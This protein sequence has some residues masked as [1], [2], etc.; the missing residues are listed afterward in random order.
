M[1]RDIYQECALTLDRV[2]REGW[3]E[4][5]NNAA[6]KYQIKV[7]ALLAVCSRETVGENKPGDGGHGRGLMQIDDRYHRKFL[8]EHEDGYDPESNIDYA[9]G[10]LKAELNRFNGKYLR[11]F[12]AYNAGGGTVIKAIHAGQDPDTYTANRDYGKDTLAR[13]ELIERMLNPNV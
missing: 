9:A 3:L 5:F 10:L 11:A 12:Q 2:K 4:F 6:R 7:E 13:M 8:Q 1:S